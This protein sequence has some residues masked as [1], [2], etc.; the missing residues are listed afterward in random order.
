MK[1][2][3]TLLGDAHRKL[4]AEEVHI[5]YPLTIGAKQLGKLQDRKH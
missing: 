5:S 3:E 1:F 2:V 4:H